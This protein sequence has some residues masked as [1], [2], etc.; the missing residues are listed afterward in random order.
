MFDA[1]KIRRET[2]FL[3]KYPW[4]DEKPASIIEFLGEDYLNIEAGIRPGLR[5]ALVDIFGEE[6][7]PER[8]SK[9][10][11]AM[12]TGA[13]GI[14]KTTFASIA[15]P[16]M[17]HWVLCLRNPQ[18]YFELLPGSKIAFMQMS[19]STKQATEV[20]F[21]DIFARIKNAKW[22]VENYPYDDK[23]QKQIRFPKEIWILPGG[24][25]ETM[26]EGYNILGGALDEMDSHKITDE[27]DYADV[28]YDAINSRVASRY[29][30]F[31]DDG[32]EAGHRGLVICIGQMKKGNGFAA[33][34][35][36]ELSKK[37]N[38]YVW[39][40]TIWESFGWERYT[41]KKTGERNSFWYDVKRKKIL[42]DGVKDMLKNVDHVLEVPTTYRNQFETNPEK[43]LRDLAGIPPASSDPFISL[44]DRIEECRE[45]WME[46]HSNE[47]GDA[48]S[49]VRDDPHRI[50]FEP[51]FRANGDGRKRHVHIDL[52]YSPDGDALGLAMGYVEAVMDIEGEKKPYIV[53]DAL[54]RMHAPPGQEILISDVRRIIYDLKEDR[55]FRVYS[56]S[57]D[58]FQSTDT[59]QQLRKKKYVTDYLSV[60]RSTLP[61]EDLRDA[62]YERRVEFPPY[63]TYLRLGDTNRVEIA[64]KELMELQY[65]GK[66]VDHPPQGSK[67]VAD[68]MAG[69][70]HTLMGD[71]TYRKGVSSI[72]A[73]DEDRDDEQVLVPD[74]TTGMGSV[75]PFPGM[76]GG[77]KAPVPPSVGGMMGLTLPPRLQ[78]K[79]K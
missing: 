17:V 38:A 63:I 41:N 8:I 37:E 2:E 32:M 6:T 74:G 72:D 59:L 26:F 20:V 15:L 77:L 21:G 40:Q 3:V 61:Y 9:Y 1:D 13:I 7:N 70:V 51:W 55:G 76:G 22:F 14:G 78:P 65:T 33:R 52:G 5:Q 34:K 42:P 50:L 46:R 36:A 18:E 16:Y 56:V 49:P 66:K 25:S 30:I 54:M 53:F 73:P 10:Q 4:F 57:M 48:P 68:A 62:I 67:D 27:K 43:A 11:D 12:F 19:T 28:G 24:S 69:V 23:F 31:S 39:R 71:R 60:D 29:P 35:Y 79:G 45:R 75:I 58:G 44:V 64:V 47:E